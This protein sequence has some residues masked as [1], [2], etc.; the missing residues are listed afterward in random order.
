MVSAE[1]RPKLRESAVN[2]LETNIKTA[3][4]PTT[5]RMIPSPEYGA[6]AACFAAKSGL[7]RLESRPGSESRN[8]KCSH[9]FGQL[10][11]LLKLIS[12]RKGT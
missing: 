12:R 4:Q 6:Q 1:S 10:Q 5:E 9:G 8:L 2:K 7:D 3:G 11:R